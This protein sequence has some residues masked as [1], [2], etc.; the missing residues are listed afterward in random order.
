MDF[1]PAGF[2]LGTDE[3]LVAVEEGRIRVILD[4][5]VDHGHVVAV[6]TGDDDVLVGTWYL[7]T[8]PARASGSITLRRR[9]T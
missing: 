1:A 2:R 5:T 4:P 9:A 8:R 6:L 7:N 3:V